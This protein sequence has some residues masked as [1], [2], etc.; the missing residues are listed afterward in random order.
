MVRQSNASAMAVW[1]IHMSK[2][3]Q[4]IERTDAIHKQDP[5]KIL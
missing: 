2:K 4:D 3:S 1:K 5:F